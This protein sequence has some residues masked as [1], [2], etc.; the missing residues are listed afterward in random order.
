MRNLRLL[1]EY[2]GTDFHGWQFQPHLRTVQ[3]VLERAVEVVLGAR[4]VL[5]A[6]GRTDAGVHARG[7]VANFHTERSMA[8]H[9]LREALNA[10]L[11][12]DVAVL[13]IDEVAP[14]FH[15]R[16]DAVARAYRYTIVHQSARPALLRRHALHR[17]GPL[18]VER[19]DEAA[20]A[21]EGTHDFTAFRS[22]HC[23]AESP[24]KTLTRLR[25]SRGADNVVWIDA[26]APSFL[27]HQVRL[28]VGALLEVGMGRASCQQLLDALSSALPRR[29][30]RAAP[31]HGLC[32]ERVDYGA[33]HTPA[34]CPAGKAT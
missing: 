23:D 27:R 32:L 25:V 15:A 11:P 5:H 1:V 29:I 34:E 6:A 14:S 30:G 3:G 12:P 2:D 19:M 18:D 10:C 17:Y 7:Q 16:R 24:I 33:A 13:H 9:R 28:M 22:V 21:L 8:C 26:V 31:A 4:P 20:R